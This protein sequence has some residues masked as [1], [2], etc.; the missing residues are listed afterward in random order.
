MVF[1]TLVI[2]LV[3]T[4]IASVPLPAAEVQAHRARMFST[5]LLEQKIEN[6]LAAKS[7]RDAAAGARDLVPILLEEQRYWDRSGVED[8]LA[9]AQN[10]LR[11]AQRL[12]D[13]TRRGDLRRASATLDDVRAHCV[14][15]HGRHPENRVNVG[16]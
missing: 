8:A 9:L 3:G 1:R 2:T 7:R 13:E 14:A 5:Q 4:S 11:T 15:C 12:A 10:N 6:A 16:R